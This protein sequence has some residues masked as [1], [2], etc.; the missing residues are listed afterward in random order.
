MV[1]ILKFNNIFILG[2]AAP[3]LILLLLTVV[4]FPATQAQAGT[5]TTY[6]DSAYVFDSHYT[7]QNA[8]MLTAWLDAVGIDDPEFLVDFET[9][10]TLD[11]NVSGVT[12][13]FPDGLVITDTSSD[14][15]AIIDN[16][17]GGSYAIGSYALGQN[18]DPYLELDFTANPV[19]YLAWYDIDQAGTSCIVVLTSGESFT[20]TLDTTSYSGNT[21]EFFGLYL[22]DDL[23]AQVL[24]DASGDGWWG[25]DNIQYGNN[26]PVPEPCTMLLLGTGLVGL[27]GARRGSKR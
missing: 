20:V 18:E 10:F 26:A 16:Y 11:Q 1:I 6:G 5:Y 7:S 15:A 21:A 25:I 3:V 12:G 22:T 2:K 14:D 19:N 23:I 4:L 24:F 27:A 9:G 17:F 8:G 13:L